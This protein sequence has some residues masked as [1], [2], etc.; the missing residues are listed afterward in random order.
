[1][2][3]ILFGSKMVFMKNKEELDV[4]LSVIKVSECKKN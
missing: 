4:K 1:M 2:S 3:V